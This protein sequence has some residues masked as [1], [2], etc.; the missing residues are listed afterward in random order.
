MTLL[1]L[2]ELAITGYGCE[3]AFFMAGLQDTA[4]ARSTRSRR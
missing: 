2:P 4:F 3:D 1:C